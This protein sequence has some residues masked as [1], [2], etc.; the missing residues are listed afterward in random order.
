LVVLLLLAKFKH[1]KGFGFEAE[2]WEE[3]Q[4]EAAALVDRLTLLSEAVS[5]Q[6][7]LIASKLG[8]WGGSLTNT[9]LADLTE[10][11][12]RLLQA[13]GASTIR[14]NEILGPVYRRIELNYWS[15]AQRLV[16]DAVNNEIST[17]HAILNSAPPEE[18]DAIIQRSQISSV[19]KERYNKFNFRQF[20]E[21]KTMDPLIAFART[22][23][24]LAG[25][26]AL[27][28]E[29]DAQASPHFIQPRTYH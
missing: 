23:P 17:I 8:L 18:R 22:C 13:A 14:V 10:Q 28:A 11:V 7:A 9:E 4:I 26:A 25:S 5:E 29:L 15:A 27:H 16:G 24:T 3:K 19:D 12:S 6:M 1:I 21:N 2:M 20:A